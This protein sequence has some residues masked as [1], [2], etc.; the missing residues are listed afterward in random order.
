VPRNFSREQKKIIALQAVFAYINEQLMV[1][2]VEC[3]G[4]YVFYRKGYIKGATEK[5]AAQTT[6]DALLLIST[7]NFVVQSPHLWLRVLL[8]LLIL[9]C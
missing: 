1:P 3:C 6:S 8:R 2:S 7:K 4:N 5:K 9:P